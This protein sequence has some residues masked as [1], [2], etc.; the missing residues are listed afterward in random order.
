MTLFEPVNG[1][2]EPVVTDV[3]TVSVGSLPASARIPGSTGSP[4][5]MVP[6]TTVATLVMPVPL[7]AV[8]STST[9]ITIWSSTASTSS[10]EHV[11]RWPVASQRTPASATV[12]TNRSPVGRSSVMVMRPFVGDGPSLVTVNT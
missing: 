11:T 5:T 9:S 6:P 8:T 10:V 1:R 7:A 2:A 4:S 12:P 3:V